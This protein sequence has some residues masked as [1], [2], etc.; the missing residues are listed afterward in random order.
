MQRESCTDAFFRPNTKGPT[1]ASPKMLRQV[2][3][4]EAIYCRPVDDEYLIRDDEESS[5]R[6]ARKIPRRFEVVP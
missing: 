4:R 1:Y 3:E 2:K 6:L 5:K